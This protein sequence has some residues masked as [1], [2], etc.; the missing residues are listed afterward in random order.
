MSEEDTQ[1]RVRALFQS[2]RES[3][4]PLMLELATSWA[5]L[6]PHWDANEAKEFH[7]KVHGIAGSAATFDCA[8]IGAVAKNLEYAFAPLLNIEMS[9]NDQYW[10]KSKQLFQQLQA[11]VKL[12]DT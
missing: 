9:E 6:E 10:S 8:E 2:Y 5:Q 7:R 11:L 12:L 3:L 4:P 1:A